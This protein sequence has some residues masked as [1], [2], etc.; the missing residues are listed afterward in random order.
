MDDDEDELAVTELI[1]GVDVDEPNARIL[2]A[3]VELV[4]K[5]G[6]RATTMDH[7]AER[8]RVARAT[9][10]RRFPNKRILLDSA[11]TWELG[12]FARELN[13]A[14]SNEHT[15]AAAVAAVVITAI[16]FVDR[17]PLLSR[18]AAEQP[19]QLVIYA[20]AG[21]RLSMLT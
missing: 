20:R 12:K 14:T 18:L 1:A 9:V 21:G 16:D 8:S 13:A 4:G 5:H 11:V 3:A 10:F 6:E 17:S 19:D 15:A 7:I 2:D